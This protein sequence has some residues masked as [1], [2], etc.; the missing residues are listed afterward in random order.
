[1][2]GDTDG[3]S[4]EL[5]TLGGCQAIFGDTGWCQAM[6]LVA[7][8]TVGVTAAGDIDDTVGGVS[9]WLRHQGHDGDPCRCR[10]RWVDVA[11]RGRRRCRR[12]AT[13]RSVTRMRHQRAPHMASRWTYDAP[14]ALPEWRHVTESSWLASGRHRGGPNTGDWRGSPPP[15]VSDGMI[16]ATAPMATV[17]S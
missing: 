1:M 11:V 12:M 17:V 13:S 15:G 9:R 14:R 4:D 16:A 6:V 5:V 3:V 7:A 8:S 2:T 10:A